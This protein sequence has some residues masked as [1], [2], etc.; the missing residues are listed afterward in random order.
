MERTHIVDGKKDTPTEWSLKRV[1]AMNWATFWQ[2]YP[3]SAQEAEAELAIPMSNAWPE[4]GVRQLTLI[5]NRIKS[6]IENDLLASLIHISIMAVPHTEAGDSLVSKAVHI[7][8]D[9]KKRRK[10]PY[11][12]HTARSQQW[13][14]ACH[15]HQDRTRYRD[16]DRCN[17]NHWAAE[18]PRWVLRSNKS[19]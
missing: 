4:R 2:F 1:T 8:K 15:S 12:K 14:W 13:N 19:S 3:R 6:Q 10:L 16:A 11:H 17:I 9:A 18:H 7:W 5:K